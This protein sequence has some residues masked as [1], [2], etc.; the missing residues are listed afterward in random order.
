MLNEHRG[1]LFRASSLSMQRSNGFSSFKPIHAP[2]THDIAETASR[3]ELLY[4]QT[5]AHK[6]C[7]LHILSTFVST[8]EVE[9]WY[10]ILQDLQDNES[11]KILYHG[12]NF[13]VFG[14]F[15]LEKAY[16]MWNPELREINA[17]RTRR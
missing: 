6:G 5:T 12:Y 2:R 4:L 9:G 3:T 11:F 10:H 7:N 14:P 15:G 13:P 17:T 16:Y 8:T 1:K